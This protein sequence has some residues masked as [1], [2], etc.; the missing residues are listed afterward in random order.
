MIFILNKQEKVINILKNG[1]GANGASPFF[2][3]VFTQDL[4]TGAETF[5]FT[6][7]ATNDISRDLIV[8]NYVAFQVDDGYKLFQIL[9]T[10]ES[11][12]D[13]LYITVYCEGAGLELINKVIRS[14]KL[15][16]ATLRR[17]M[18]TVLND[19]G[20]NVGFIPMTV[21]ES[22]DLELED[23]TVYSTL[24]TYTAKFGV[25]MA[26]RV[27]INKGR[28]SS[29]Y[30][31][32]YTQR[33][34]V[35]GKRFSFGRDIEGI[36]R[37]VDSTELFTALIGKGNNGVTF[38]DI[39][40]SGIDKPKGQDFI[41]DTEAYD[42]Y[43]NNGYHIM[44]IF[45]YDTSSPE[46]LLRETKKQLDKVKQ[47]KIQ[48][49]VSV[50]MLSELLGETWD[51][52]RIGDTVAVVDNSFNPPIHLMARVSKLETSF[53]NKQSD[54]CTL[55]NFI[56]VKSNITEEMRKIASEL[57]G[58][59][60][61][62]FPIGGEDIKEGAVTGQHIY[63]DS[64]STEHLIADAITAGKIKADS[65][66][67]KHLQ[68]D[69]IKSK[70]ISAEQI[71]A[72]HIKSGTITAD[73]IEVGT[74]TAESGIIADATIG[75]AQIK[76]AEITVAKIQDAFVDSLV[77]NQGKFQSAHIGTLTSDNI[78]T[79]TL[80]AEHL[81]ATVIEAIN[82]SIGK[83]DADHIDVG[84]LEVEELDAG[85]ITTGTLDADR[86]TS[87]VIS[88]INASIENA[89][90]DS[91]RIGNL[92]ADKITSGEIST[93]ILKS[94]IITAINASI[95]KINADHI[96]V[97]SIKVENIDA[98]QITT[99]DLDADRI[100]SNVI[101]AINSYAGT[102]KIKQG[103]IE[104]LEVGSANITDLDVSKL[105]GD[106]IDAKFIDVEKI[107]IKD[108]NITGTI[109]ASKISGGTLDASNITV[110]NLKADSITTG[111]LVVQGENLVPNS[112][113]QRDAILSDGTI[114]KGYYKW[115]MIAP[116]YSI[117]ETQKLDGAGVVKYSSENT[118]IGNYY[119]VGCNDINGSYTGYIAK[120]GDIFVVS[121]YFKIP[122]N[123]NITSDW[124]PCVGIWYYTKKEDGT[125]ATVKSA[126]TN[127]DMSIVDEWQ[128]VVV[129]L[130]APENT[131]YVKPVIRGKGA[132]TFF[133]SQ[134]MMSKGQLA[135][136][137]KPHTD[138]LI[139]DGA[140]EE[141]K[142]A[143]D[144]V[145]SDK[146]NVEELFVGENAFIKSLKAVEI[147]ASNITTGKIS[148]DR[149]DIS[150]MISFEALDK[151]LQPLFDVTGDKTYINGG[152]IG[153]NTIKANSIDLLSGLTVKGEDNT[154]TF[155][156][157]SNGDVEVNG[158]LKSGNFDED[159]NTGYRLSTDGTAI[160][161]QAV[162]KGDVILPNAGIT[163]YGATI[164][165]ENILQATDYSMYSVTEL[166][167]NTDNWYKSPKM[168][169]FITDYKHLNGH[170]EDEH[171]KGS[172]I[173]V[174][175]FDLAT[176]GLTQGVLNPK[177]VGLN[178]NESTEYIE[179]KPNTK[180]T[181][182]MWVYVGGDATGS[183]TLHVWGYDNNGGNRTDMANKVLASGWKG[184]F[185]YVTFTFTT[186][187]RKYYQPRIYINRKTAETTT[188]VA[189]CMFYNL[190][191]EE[192][193]VATPYSPSPKDQFDYVRI[194]AGSNFQGRDSAPFR[195]TQKGDVFATNATV[196]GRMYGNYDNGNI[197]IHNNEIVIDSVSTYLDDNGK[198]IKVST[199]NKPS[200]NP[201][202]RL[203]SG[204]S[205][206]NT[207][208]VLG[209]LS[210]RKVMFDNDT[211][212]LTLNTTALNLNSQTKDSGGAS[213]Y[214]NPKGAYNSTFG[215][216]SNVPDTNASMTIGYHAGTWSNTA[217]VTHNG[218][219]GGVNGDVCFK[220][221]DN[222]ED[223]N[224]FVQG[225]IRMRNSIQSTVQ[226][227]EMRSVKNE[228][229]G[230]YAN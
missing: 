173:V 11:H 182:S 49:E 164:G 2:D 85:K 215:V 130:E 27:D 8:G 230:F 89:T 219:R 86:I 23:A 28:I 175:K 131:H 127:V 150:G 189:Q 113:F 81:T 161:N 137:W 38:K 185:E 43:N 109:T 228:G 103:Q 64:I 207:D 145:S 91:A 225:N 51:K 125:L 195:V 134:P 210:D 174:C 169:A 123:H 50:V 200:S 152:M 157:A 48:Y 227:I 55:A 180:Y 122:T 192:G 213:V 22:L 212:S 171:I 112:T 183:C 12:E 1:G 76:D 186:D 35:T 46:E 69:S 10:E 74:I 6:T 20:W 52:V 184:R 149:I 126:V 229:W 199:K 206:I 128:R 53:T 162:V 97:S 139:S 36:K 15:T 66:E 16:S 104:T 203:G 59:V 96:D 111:S 7:I 87:S 218:S 208:L 116:Y 120:K 205:I 29:K 107:L 98:G 179:L 106:K 194:W 14:T 117:D 56:E 136:I 114:V 214:F 92:S 172:N 94:N 105:T 151:D 82:A 44:G 202:I 83:I 147:D 13:T 84:S 78:T 42:R 70:H 77:A 39:Q 187:T 146:L 196:S 167:N 141:D 165:N 226:N 222:T 72:E 209:T 166:F 93:D 67:T 25:E 102:M 18:E 108:A 140:I 71:E 135:S 32:L 57:E 95:G 155:S 34:K 224:F 154:T 221:S 79:E 144:A 21:Q 99:G 3:D 61:S 204:D 223:L 148:G 88:A 153:A 142:I 47:P 62:K 211:R 160:L 129:T 4:S 100:T 177:G 40:I 168:E 26:F 181:F 19:T 121:A 191:L 30:V 118:T 163:N 216:E 60:E 197:H 133:F 75:T 24:Q 143:D 170:A 31:D 58:Y 201:Y 159:K 80:K 68:A 193:A 101:S 178:G 158:L 5:T 63:K 9:Q 110:K 198:E 217:I 17:F 90:I 176:S 73:K 37:T 124:T 190:K 119:A 41:A 33:G 138:E 156:I 45:R 220:R 54:T 115:S 132:G 188:G 65:I